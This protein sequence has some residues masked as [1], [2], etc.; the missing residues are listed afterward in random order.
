MADPKKNWF[1]Q[2]PNW[3]RAFL[4]LGRAGLADRVFAL[5]IVVTRELQ[6]VLRVIGFAPGRPAFCCSLAAG[7]KSWR[8]F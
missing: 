6:G 5:E 1:F 8:D 3:P 7:R 4:S 2:A